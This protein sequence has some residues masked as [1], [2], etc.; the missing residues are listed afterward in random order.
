METDRE[1]FQNLFLDSAVELE[2]GRLEFDRFHEIMTHLLE[3]RISLDE[4]HHI[5]CDIFRLDARMVRLGCSLSRTYGTWLV[6]N[7]S[8]AHYQWIVTKF[9]EILF[10]RDAALSYRLGVMKPA[11]EYYRKALS[12]FGLN[13]ASC[14]FIDDLS[15]NVE[16]AVR[17]GMIGIVYEGTDR[18]LE[19]LHN[20]GVAMSDLTE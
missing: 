6:S 15:E 1:A 19:E 11:A 5:W 14:V 12:L 4:F 17:A 8:E 10:Y 20:I 13:P 16:G 2:M 3:T 9:P 7:T 18:L